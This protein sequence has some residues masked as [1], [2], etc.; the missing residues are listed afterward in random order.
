MA[1]GDAMDIDRLAKFTKTESGSTG[2]SSNAPTPPPQKRAKEQPPSLPTGSGL[3]A[4][5]P[6]GGLGAAPTTNGTTG[7]NIWLTFPLRGQNNVTINFAREVEKRYGFAAL[8]PRLAARKERQRQL[9]AASNALEKAAGLGSA[10]EMSLDLSEPD[11]ENERD[12]Q[13]DDT[14][15][16]QP[17][18]G[19]K[20][21]RKR[22]AEDYDRNDE[23]VDDTELAWEES[24]LM[25]KDGFFVYSGPLMSENEKNLT[26]E[27]YVVPLPLLTLAHTN[28]SHSADGSVKRGR[29]RGRGGATRGDASGRGRGTGGGRGSRGGT[30]VR[31]PR[32]TKA[33]RAAMELE[34]IEREKMAAQMAKG[35]NAVPAHSSPAQQ[36]PTLPSQPPYA[37]AVG[38][39]G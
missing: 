21:R 36:P 38:T 34:K 19:T 30:T 28:Y 16:A 7:T 22:K 39:A 10:D 35:S 27:R 32:V 24:A 3:L 2:P 11:S 5:T 12:A 4:G 13:G 37:A 20:K 15:N 8:H 6:L 18:D 26:I 23:F 31:K 1:S 29:G 33:D 17:G 14:S 25:A 9:A